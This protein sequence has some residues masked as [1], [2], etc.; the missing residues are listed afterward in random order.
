MFREVIRAWPGD[1]FETF[2]PYL[3]E[4]VPLGSRDRSGE[5]LTRF[6]LFL[7]QR[8]ERL[9]SRYD[10]DIS[11]HLTALLQW[12]VRDARR[13]YGFDWRLIEP[14]AGRL[15][16][17]LRLGQLAAPPSDPGRTDIS[18][19][20]YL[21]TTSGVGNVCRHTLTAL[22]GS[23][24][25]VEGLDTDL[26]VVSDRS[27]A[28]VEAL[29]SERAS[30]RVHI[31]ANVNA[32]QLPQVLAH[33]APRLERPAYRISIPAWELEDFPDPWLHAFDDIDEIWAQTPWIQRML[34]SKLDKPVINMPVYLATE[35]PPTRPRSRFGLPKDTFL[36]YLAFDFL[37]FIKRKN[38]EAAVE[39]LRR[40]PRPPLGGR[41]G[42]VIKTMNGAQAPEALAR[43]R[44]V[45]GDDPDIFVIDEVLTRADT[46]ALTMACDCVVSLHR[47]EGLGLVVAEAMA[48]GRPVIATDYAATA[49][50]LTP[51]T[52]FPVNYR[53]VP[54]EPDD[55]PMA[56]GQSW[57]EP[58]IDHA[59]W[60]MALVIRCPDEAARRSRSAQ[61]RLEARH[62]RDAVLTCQ[63]NRLRQIGVVP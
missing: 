33:L 52:G 36:F 24:L 61:V 46:L 53:L 32:D 19:V 44:S 58:D 30:G 15:G 60:L 20:G 40:M 27:A 34:V 35:A 26:N 10:K 42:L 31:F 54:V 55:Y 62:G 29:L 57:A 17:R 38:P 21:R 1:P 18:V 59:A 3:H 8:L 23:G 22:A 25:R 16:H 7:W 47:C 9:H 5:V 37:S 13:E 51:Q 6:L 41:V 28:E 49:E 11:S 56:D 39:A 50:L 45:V 14:V 48:L 12:Y 4:A 43:F 2:E 63:L